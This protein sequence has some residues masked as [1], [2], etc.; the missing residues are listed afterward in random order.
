MDAV[1]L[2][3]SPVPNNGQDSTDGIRKLYIHHVGASAPRLVVWLV[4]LEVGDVP[5]TAMPSVVPLDNWNTVAFNDPGTGFGAAPRA[6]LMSLLPPA[7]WN[8][9]AG[10]VAFRI[11][12]GR[13]NGQIVPIVVVADNAVTSGLDYYYV[14]LTADWV[15]WKQCSVAIDDFA[16]IGSPGSWPNVTEVQFRAGR[17]AAT[18]L[19]DSVLNVDGLETRPLGDLFGDL[20]A[21]AKNLTFRPPADWDAALQHVAFDLFSYAATGQEM[22]LLCMSEDISADGPDYY[23]YSIDVDWTGW[24]RFV[25]PFEDF[26]IA[27]QPLG[28]DQLNEIRF[29]T[30]GWGMTLTTGTVLSLH[31][32]GT[33]LPGHVFGIPPAPGPNVTFARRADWPVRYGYI[34]FDLFSVNANRQRVDAVFHADDPVSPTP[35]FYW[36]TTYADWSGW[37]TFAVPMSQFTSIGSPPGWDAV[38]SVSFHTTEYGGRLLADSLLT[39]YDAGPGL[40]GVIFGSSPAP[41]GTGQVPIPADWDA[42]DGLVEFDIYSEVANGQA[43]QAIFASEN[44]NGVPDGSDYYRFEIIADWTGWRHFSIPFSEFRTARQP[45]GWD[46]LT[47]IRFYTSGW[48]TTRLPDTYLAVYNLHSGH[49][50]PDPSAVRAWTVYW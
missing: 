17:D 15:G 25:V 6:E 11:Y 36:F 21:P 20:P 46:Q 35:D 9:E 50:P 10:M 32:F 48:N 42:A 41:S 23:R 1:P 44:P 5:P 4:P 38:T 37:K 33:G 24:R 30:D 26:S 43:I 14:E 19:S 27:R 28:W 39:L 8:P 40:P 31:G 45:L 29:Y 47:G 16:A 34:T 12:S 3:T 13:A 2:P 7:G 18:R 22:L 49:T